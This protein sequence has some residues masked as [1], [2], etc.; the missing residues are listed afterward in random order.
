M[1]Y[2]LIGADGNRYGPADIDTLVQWVGEGRIVASTLLIE[3]GTEREVR[4]DSITAVAAALRRVSGETPGA[5]IERQP[6]EQGELPT[7][8][9]APG[10][11]AA[12]VQPAPQGTRP[13]APGVQLGAAGHRSKI[14]AGLLGIFLGWL[15]IHRF[16]LGYSG[17]GLLMLLLTVLGGAA[18]SFMCIPGLPCGFVWLWGFIEGIICLCGGMR[19]ADGLKLRD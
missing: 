9:A 14:A 12:P 7:A 15:G 6:F 8:T 19:D 10:R 11:A 18:S 3:R 4:A 13:V 2:F 1:Y 17:I 16:Y 5:V